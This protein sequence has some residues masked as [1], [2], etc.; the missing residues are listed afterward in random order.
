MFIFV[1][2]S[3]L[4]K[5]APFILYT[6]HGDYGAEVKLCQTKV[7]LPKVNTYRFQIYSFS[8]DIYLSMTV[9]WDG[10]ESAPCL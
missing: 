5:H 10:V 6:F 7:E 8:D 1:K 2:K 3:Q 9:R 4:S